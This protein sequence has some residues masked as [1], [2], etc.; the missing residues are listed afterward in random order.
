VAGNRPVQTRLGSPN[1]VEALGAFKAEG[2]I[3]RFEARQIAQQFQRWLGDQ[4]DTVSRLSAY[5]TEFGC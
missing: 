3:T 4:D 1:I 2:K 5:G